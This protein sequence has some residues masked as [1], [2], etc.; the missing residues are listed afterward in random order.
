MLATH[1]LNQG[2]ADVTRAIIVIHGALR[3]AEGSFTA[4]QHA[5]TM[6]GEA[7]RHALVLAPQFLSEV[8]A[9]RYPV[10]S[11]YPS[12]AS[13]DGRMGASP[14]FVVMIRRTSGSVRCLDANAPGDAER[15]QALASAGPA[16]GAFSRSQFVQR[17]AAAGHA[18]TVLSHQGIHTRFVVANPSSYLY[19]DAR[20]PTEHGFV[21]FPVRR[22]RGFDHY[23]YGLDAPNPYVASQTPQALMWHYARQQVIY[24]LGTLDADATHLDRSCAA[25]AQGPPAWRAGRHIIDTCPWSWDTR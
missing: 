9:V 12:G 7:G 18:P 24:L 8:D 3:N 20:R 6:A 1:V 19:F 4:M 17:Y 21:T 15:S 16:R 25:E 14:R 11:M 23:K 10:P 5:M 13:M 22:C 2:H